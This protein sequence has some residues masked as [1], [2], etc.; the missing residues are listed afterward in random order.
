MVTNE[1]SS[2]II[3][4]AVYYETIYHLDA[5]TALIKDIY[6]AADDN[7]IVSTCMNG[8]IFCWN[9]TDSDNNVMK[10]YDHQERTIYNHIELDIRAID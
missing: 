4:D 10:I 1:K 7:Y 9:L 8:Y 6:I 5:H 2:L 3:Y